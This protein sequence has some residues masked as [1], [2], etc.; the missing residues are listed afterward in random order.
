VWRAFFRTVSAAGRKPACVNVTRGGPGRSL[1]FELA[2]D[3]TDADTTSADAGADAASRVEHQEQQ[4][5]Q[6]QDT[7]HDKQPRRRRLVL[8]FIHGGA[9][10]A[11]SARQYQATY[12]V[13][14]RRLRARGVDAR[15]F[16]V[17][18]P[19]APEH[20]YP[21]ARDVI[22]KDM[23]WLLGGAC[24][25]DAIVIGGD[26]AGANL[27]LSALAHMRDTGRLPRAPDGLLLVSPCVDLSDGCVF[28]R[29]DAE[30]LRSG[31]LDY[32]PR[33]K[34]GGA[35][36]HLYAADRSD[37]YVSPGLLPSLAGL[38]AREVL[39]IS[40]GAELMVPDIRLFAKKLLAAAAGQAPPA[41]SA[42]SSGASS[43]ASSGSSGSGSGSG[44]SGGFRATY[45]EE[46]GRVHSWPM[47]ML[48]NLVEKQEPMFAF[49][50]RCCSSA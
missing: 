32:L 49:M 1:W 18:Y 38:A 21:A 47:L 28:A 2:P 19:L 13:W 36:P 15:I 25:D 14:L 10:V 27:A 29:R 7:Q 33:C 35:L 4:Q 12:A 8:A 30:A 39:L 5:Q 26:S 11:G 37:P 16:S 45:I 3:A 6:Q 50:E 22:E 31:A 43:D 17:S 42:P 23:A 24:G 20:R 41:P 9:F 34:I 46:P 40:G 48:P 44:N